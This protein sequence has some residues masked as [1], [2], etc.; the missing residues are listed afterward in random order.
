MTAVSY[1]WSLRSFCVCCFQLV[2]IWK[3][4][5]LLSVLVPHPNQGQF[6]DG[7]KPWSRWNGAT[8]TPAGQLQIL[9]IELSVSRSR[10]TVHKWRRNFIRDQQS[11]YISVVSHIPCATLEGGTGN[12]SRSFILVPFETFFRPKLYSWKWSTGVDRGIDAGT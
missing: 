5:I 1:D 11:I 3:L 9:Q 12:T 4:K 6:T 10:K 8:G 2:E 7:T